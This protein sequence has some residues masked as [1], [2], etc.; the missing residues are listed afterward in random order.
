MTFHKQ[1]PLPCGRTEGG[2]LCD[3]WQ[4]LLSGGRAH[5]QKKEQLSKKYLPALSA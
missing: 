1:I 2:F 5:C 3:A 4:P